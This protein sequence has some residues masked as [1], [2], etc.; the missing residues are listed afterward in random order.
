MKIF[1]NRFC[2]KMHSREEFDH[3]WVLLSEHFK[4]TP[5]YSEKSWDTGRR[6]NYIKFNAA[7][8]YIWASGMHDDGFVYFENFADFKKD[9]LDEQ[10]VVKVKHEDI[11][12]YVDVSNSIALI[13]DRIKLLE[14]DKA[15]LTSRLEE[16]KNKLNME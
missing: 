9:Y 8:N 14:E 10:Y 4:V 2:I 3:A 11:M 1:P 12:E 7:H 16:I 15:P 5:N 6:N 13:D